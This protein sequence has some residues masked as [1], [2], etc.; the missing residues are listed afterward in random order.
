MSRR[1]PPVERVR[2][3]AALTGYTATTSQ[4]GVPM[5]YARHPGGWSS[6]CWFGKGQYYKVFANGKG[7]GC[8]R[9]VEG[10]LL[11][12]EA[13]WPGPVHDALAA[14]DEAYGEARDEPPG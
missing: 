6:I 8:A 13:I 3:A 5:A 1:L 14:L 4:R 10:V 11:L 2:I 12:V 9:T 7:F